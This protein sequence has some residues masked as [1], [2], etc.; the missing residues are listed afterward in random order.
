MGSGFIDR[1]YQPHFGTQH[2]AADRHG[3]TLRK[4]P[5]RA[6]EVDRNFR[7]TCLRWCL[8][9]A[10]AINLAEREGLFA[11][12]AAHLS[13]VARDCRRQGAP[14]S[15]AAASAA[16]RQTCCLYSRGRIPSRRPKPDS[17]SVWKLIKTWRKERD[18]N[19]IQRPS[20]ISKLRIQKTIRSLGTPENPIAV[21]GAVTGNP[22]LQPSSPKS[23]GRSIS[24]AAARTWE[25]RI[26][27]ARAVVSSS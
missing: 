20:Q 8:K 26:R 15:F 14:A 7:T 21:T 18:S 11:G 23:S 22:S 4:G 1:P 19:R 9:Q 12:C 10:Q 24:F 6:G 27:E 16:T 17:D 5:L 3:V 2:R 13:L 25:A